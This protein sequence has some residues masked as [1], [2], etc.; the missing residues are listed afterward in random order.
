MANI[1]KN[2]L[3]KINVESL[4]ANN[5]SITIDSNKYFVSYSTVIAVKSGYDIYLDKKYWDYSS[6]TSRYR[7]IFLN[8][9]TKE[10][11]KKIVNKEI[12][13]IDLN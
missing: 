9:T 3:H 2:H 10:T 1:K 6:T 4:N 12:K 11:K 8:L 5:Q 13:L 7:N